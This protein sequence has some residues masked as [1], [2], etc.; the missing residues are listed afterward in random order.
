MSNPITLSVKAAN[1]HTYRCHLASP[2]ASTGFVYALG[3]RVYG[4]IGSPAWNTLLG[5][6][7]R[8]FK[9]YGK[10]AFVVAAP[11]VAEEPVTV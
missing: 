1:G 10:W 5:K 8:S 6:Y 3:H 2:D 7:E 4:R 9:A 11:A